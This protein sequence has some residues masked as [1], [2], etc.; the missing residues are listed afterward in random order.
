MSDMPVSTAEQQTPER[1]FWGR[2]ADGRARALFGTAYAIAFL[3]TAAAIWLVAIAPGATAGG[4][5]RTAASQ[6]VLFIL[7]ANLILI[8]GLAA[9]IG[10]RV[11][12]LTRNRNDPGARLHLRFVTLF[13]LV[14]VVPAVLIALVFG[15]LVNR[16]VDQWFSTNVRSAVENGAEIGRAYVADVGA[17][18]EVD[19]ETMATELGGVRDLFDNRIQFSRALSQ[20][21]DF[22]G[23]PALYI[24]DDE[25][26]V[27]ASGEQPGAPPYVAP[28][29]EAFETVAGGEV[30]PTTVT[31]NPDMVRA[32][33]PLPDY[34]HAYLYVVRPLAPGLI[35]RMRNGEESITAYRA[36]E[37]SRARIQAAFALSYLETALLVLVGAVW[38]AM[39]AASSISAPIGR[40]VKAADQVAGGDLDARVDNAGAPSEIIVLSEA[41]NRMTE[42]IKTQ[43]AALKTASDEAQGRSLFIET[44]LSGVSAGVIGLDR[45]RRISA[46]NDSASQLLGLDPEQVQGLRL[47][48]VAPELGELSERGEAH[49]EEDID[50]SRD[51]E[52]LRLR[53]RIEGGQGGEMVL[54]FDDITRLVTAQ[55]NAAWRDV[56]RRIAHEI[57]NPLTPIQLSAERLRRRYRERVGD[58]VEVFDRCTETIIR[59]V[60]D[61]GRM[62]DE[63]SSFARMPAPRFS[64]EN[65]AEMLREAVFAQRVAVPDI[66]VDLVEPLPSVV[67][68]CDGRMV[69]QAL[70]NILKNAGEAV[71]AKRARDPVAEEA[72]GIIAR[73]DIEDERAV[74]TIEDDGVGLP[75]KDRD[76]LTEPYVTTREKGTGLGLAIV[77]R[78]CEDHGGELR[79]ADAET[80]SGA[81]VCLIFPLT[82]NHKSAHRAS[83]AASVAS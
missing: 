4:D 43:Q 16:G 17:G 53:V 24:L 34:G 68:Q 18:L 67:L 80:L 41:F 79:L 44:V 74:F 50:V 20:I 15:L 75:A 51:G 7:L 47:A 63:F 58:D 57:K 10:G 25:G 32:L 70:A 38:L 82:Q 2:L 64:M 29:R 71:G 61:I 28:P 45:M 66:G 78:I 54:T 59:Q 23:Y 26:R 65:P 8:A 19:L 49:I 3:I 35:Q 6:I 21:G 55:R 31:E 11:L 30:A 5:A 48:D 40:L 9:V 77:K 72:L 37:E 83:G 27:L 60:G 14:S 52:A 56:A 33:Y 1:S 69:G 36:A 42:D 76:R 39:S 81:R 73:L 62:V 12:R 22:F 46:I 13:S